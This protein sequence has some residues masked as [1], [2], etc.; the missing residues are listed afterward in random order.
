MRAQQCVGTPGPLS[1]IQKALWVG[2]AL[3]P[4]AQ[5]TPGRLGGGPPVSRARPPL[6]RG[7]AGDHGTVASSVLNAVRRRRLGVGQGHG[8][9]G[10]DTL[11]DLDEATG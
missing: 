10:R 2:L 4:R 9:S 8:S 7:N 1:H 3:E 6:G 5:P 11:A